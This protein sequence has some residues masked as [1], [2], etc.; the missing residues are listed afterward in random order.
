MT[1]ERAIR[2][3]RGLREIV[4]RKTTNPHERA[5]AKRRLRELTAAHNL[6]ETD[7][8]P[9]KTVTA[10]VKGKGYWLEQIAV[11]VAA[12]R[13]CIASVRSFGIEIKG[14]EHGTK[15]AAEIYQALVAQA[16]KA[17]YPTWIQRIGNDACIA[18]GAV[19]WAGFVETTMT[20]IAPAVPLDPADAPPPDANRPAATFEAAPTERFDAPP[21]ASAE[22]VE[23]IGK[24]FDRLARNPIMSQ[25]LLDG[26]YQ[27]GYETGSAAA[28]I[29]L[30]PY[31]E[32]YR[33][34][35]KPKDP[36]VI[37]GLL[38]AHRAVRWKTINQAHSDEIF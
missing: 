16:E 4:E 13:G 21:S 14:L 29:A 20:R 11:A 2:T 19:F 22:E 36:P 12:S 3:A 23:R 7:V 27:D 34:P 30:K 26:I 24:L 15:N 9:V 33:T 17:P 18:W 28:S 32:P 6:T 1:R 5:N 35:R 25:A 37:R 38:P 8:A 10:V 31:R